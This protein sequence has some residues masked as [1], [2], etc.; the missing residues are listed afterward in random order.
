MLQ[1]SDISPERRRNGAPVSRGR[2]GAD[3]L[4]PLLNRL[5]QLGFTVPPLYGRNHNMAG[6]VPMQLSVRSWLRSGTEH[7]TA[8]NGIRTL[9]RDHIP[10]TLSLSD[11]GNGDAAIDALQRF[12]D[13]LQSEIGNDR[14][15]GASIGI[16]VHTRQLPLQAFQLIADSVPGD[17]PRYVILDGLQMAPQHNRRGEPDTDRNWSFLWRNRMGSVAL[18]P[19]YG[20]TVRT[21]C[22]LL[23]DESTV[24]VLPVHGI[25]VPAESAWLPVSLAL[26]QF[27]DDSGNLE[28]RQLL[29]ALVIGVELL[30]KV[31]DRLQWPQPGQLADARLNRRLAISITGLGDLVARRGL[32]PGD[33]D[34]LRWLSAIVVRIRK[35]LW[36]RSSQMARVDGCLPA[37]CDNDPSSRWDDCAHRESWR[38]HWRMALEK[39]A[40]RHRNILVLSPYSV[41]PSTTV[42]NAGYTDLLPVIANADAWSFADIP[43]FPGWDLDEFKTF[44]RR[45]WAVIQGCKAGTLVAAGV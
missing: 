22:P 41:L 14:R 8:I 11:L 12:C 23:V 38:Y 28:W 34:T 19:A 35:I 25:Q 36:Q 26:P 27:A 39:S 17:G 18:K 32:D 1:E 13:F 31:I 44:H 43:N 16:C 21:A 15:G 30:D 40:V 33:L 45:A 5:Q 10:L 9:L 7:E 24:S 29:R 42:C 37:L 6:G 2:H 3:P 4:Y 20:V